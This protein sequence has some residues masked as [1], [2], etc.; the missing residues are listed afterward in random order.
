MVPGMKQRIEVPSVPLVGQTMVL[1][2]RFG[3]HCIIWNVDPLIIDADAVMAIFRFPIWIRNS[4][5]I[6][7]RTAQSLAVPE[8]VKPA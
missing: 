5:A 8:A 3:D 1:P 7:I 6:N 2:Y 4:K